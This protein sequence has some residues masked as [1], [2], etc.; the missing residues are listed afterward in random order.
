[1]RYSAGIY[2]AYSTAFS[3]IKDPG[4]FACLKNRKSKALSWV[5]S[6]VKYRFSEQLLM[7]IFRRL[8]TAD[9]IFPRII[10]FL[11]FGGFVLM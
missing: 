1:L 3:S 2:S 8:I 11:L 4:I 6:P 10:S 9:T 5:V 7:Y